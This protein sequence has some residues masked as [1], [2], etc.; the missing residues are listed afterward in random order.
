VP[1][2]A[3][4]RPQGVARIET[5]AARHE[6]RNHI[7]CQLSRFELPIDDRETEGILNF[8]GIRLRQQCRQ[9]LNVTKGGGDKRGCGVSPLQKDAQRFVRPMARGEQDGVATGDGAGVEQQVQERTRRSAL[10]DF[11]ARHEKF[12]RVIKIAL[13]DAVL[14]HDARDVDDV[15]GEPLD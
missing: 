4:F 8:G 9:R 14:D 11:P 15:R 10:A 13:L 3:A 12:E 7:E 2:R 5:S 6:E 1:S